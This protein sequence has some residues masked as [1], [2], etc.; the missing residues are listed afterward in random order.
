MNMK[1]KNQLKTILE[2]AEVMGLTFNEV[3][4][5]NFAII[6]NNFIIGISDEHYK[7]V[8]IKSVVK[9]KFVKETFTFSFNTKKFEW[10][11]K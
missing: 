1:I 6:N 7:V 11:I 4:R 3:I 8:E 2:T 10:E 9:G 5:L